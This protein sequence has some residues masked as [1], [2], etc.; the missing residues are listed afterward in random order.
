MIKTPRTKIYTSSVFNQ[1]LETLVL[2]IVT[3]IIKT[4]L[5]WPVPHLQKIVQYCGIKID[6]KFVVKDELCLAYSL[7]KLLTSL[8]DK[9]GMDVLGCV[10]GGVGVGVGWGEG[11]GGLVRIA[12]EHVWPFVVYNEWSP[13]KWCLFRLVKTLQGYPGLQEYWRCK[14]YV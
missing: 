9:T 5:T 4:N 10:C 1:S 6:I 3:C 13:F 7:I 8:S 12:G 2:K 14:Y 11:G